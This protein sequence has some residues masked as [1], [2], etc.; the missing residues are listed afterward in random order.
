MFAPAPEREYGLQ[1]PCGVAAF[2]VPTRLAST[3]AAPGQD[4]VRSAPT[5][6]ALCRVQACPLAAGLYTTHKEMWRMAG[7][8]V[9][10]RRAACPLWRQVPDQP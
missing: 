2:P 8:C 9:G 10:T 5:P 7:G 4:L 1:T 6:N 3:A